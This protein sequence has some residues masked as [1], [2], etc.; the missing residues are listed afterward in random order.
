MALLLI[1]ATPWLSRAQFLYKTN[2]GAITI[3]GYNG[4]GGAVA[5]P[6]TINGFP[7]VEIATNAFASKTTITSVVIPG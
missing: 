1:I 2:N 3:I 7:V 5:I 6:D 4:S